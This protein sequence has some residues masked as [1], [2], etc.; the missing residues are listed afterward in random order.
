M[1]KLNQTQQTQTQAQQTQQAQQE[2][3]VYFVTFPSKVSREKAK[4]IITELRRR[5]PSQT[6]IFMPKPPPG[7]RIL[8]NFDGL[9]VIVTFPYVKKNP[10]Q[11]QS[12][13]QAPTQ[14][15]FSLRELIKNKT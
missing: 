14:E 7:K 15:G 1:K 10:E 12:P 9:L 8:L 5:Y 4:E 13:K 2:T 3:Q 6:A 11:E